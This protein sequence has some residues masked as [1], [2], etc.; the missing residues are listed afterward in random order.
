LLLT[1]VS[2]GGAPAAD[3]VSVQVYDAHGVAYPAVPFAVPASVGSGRELGSVVIYAPASDDLAVRIDALGLRDRSPVSEGVVKVMLDRGRQVGATILLTGERLRDGDGDGVPDEI[4]DCP[5]VK[6]PLQEDGDGDLRGDACS[7]DAGAGDRRLPAGAHPNGDPCGSGAD[8]AS[9]QCVDRV[10]CDSDC[11]GP[12]RACTLPGNIGSCVPVPDGQDPHDSCAEQ[13]KETCGADG[14]CD[15]AGA[16]RRQKAGIP[17]RPPSCGPGGERLAAGACDGAGACQSAGVMP[18]APYGCVQAACRTSCQTSDDCAPGK[19]CLQGSC[20]LRPLGTACTSNDDCNSLHCVDGVCCDTAECAGAC[21]SCKVSGLEGMC[22]P[23]RVTDTPRAPG[24][25]PDAPATCG[26]TGRCSGAGSCEKYGANT[27][28]GVRSCTGADEVTPAACDG[29]GVCVEGRKRSCAPYFCAGDACSKR[30]SVD[31]DCISGYYCDGGTCKVRR[32][33]G[34]TCNEA[35]ECASN[36][37]A[38]GICCRT[39][40]TSGFYCAGGDICLPKRGVSG[41]CE[42]GFECQQGFCTDGRCCES[43]CLD[44]CLRCNDPGQPGRCVFM[45][46]GLPDLNA[47]STCRVCDAQGTCRIH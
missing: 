36:V 17:C 47:G 20:G 9:G 2:A 34:A 31:G 29:T 16:C 1:I 40:C 13:P 15:G 19:M 23:L 12:C 45:P 37:C 25:H 6:N 14:F 10:C 4:D 33:L 44:T 46:V 22:S 26:R 35:R 30:C 21:R 8:C 38:D 41:A 42:K 32:G 27:P 28:C 7:A 5:E 24:C 43:A 3:G 18:C 39:P 11:Q